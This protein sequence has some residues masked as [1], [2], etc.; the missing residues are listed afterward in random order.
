MNLNWGKRGFWKS[1]TK[2]MANANQQKP[3]VGKIPKVEKRIQMVTGEDMSKHPRILKRNAYARPDYMPL[4]KRYAFEAG[5]EHGFGDSPYKR[6]IGGT[7]YLQM[8][9]DLGAQKR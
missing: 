8:A 1:R 9:N 6:G 7:N 2:W 3:K 4:F 5:G